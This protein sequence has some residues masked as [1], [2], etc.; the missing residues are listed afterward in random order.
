MS[1]KVLIR[2]AAN[3]ELEEFPWDEGAK[4]RFHLD[5]G[6]CEDLEAGKVVWRGTTGFHL[7]DAM[8]LEE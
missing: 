8:M 5:E 1:N 7:D 2:E 3:Q 6:D 4:R